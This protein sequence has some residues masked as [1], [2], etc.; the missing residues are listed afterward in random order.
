MAAPEAKARENID[1]MLMDAGYVL[2]D[3]GEFNRGAARGVAV[4]EYPTEPRG[5][6]WFGFPD[7]FSLVFKVI[8]VFT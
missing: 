8:P 4:R 5:L 2:Q 6:K 7:S 1:R 3:M